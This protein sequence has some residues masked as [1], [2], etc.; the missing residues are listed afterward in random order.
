MFDA[1]GFKKLLFPFLEECMGR[2]LFMTE[3]GFIEDCI[4]V[5]VYLCFFSPVVHWL[6]LWF[7][8][9]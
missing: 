2:L 4:D 5:C 8:N 3:Y 7:R 9:P 6:A 1:T